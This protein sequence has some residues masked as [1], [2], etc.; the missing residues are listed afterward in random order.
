MS[1][2]FF[3]TLS[4]KVEPFVPRDTGKVAMYTCGPTVYARAHIGNFRTFLVSDLLHR[5][6]KYLGY[7]VTWVMNLT[8]IDDKTIKGANA[9][10][11]SLR[12]Y[13]DKYIALFHE[14]R[15]IIGIT[16]ATMYPRATEHIP[17]MVKMVEDLVSAKHA[18]LV[19]GS[20]YFKIDS[21][22]SYGQLARLNM[23]EMR[24]GERVASDEYEKEDVRDF[25]LWKNW[26]EVDGP[27]AWDTSLGKGRPGWHLE[28]SAMSLKYLGKGFDIHL[29]GVDLIFPHHQNEIAQTEGVTHEPL[30]RY[31]V[32]SEHL[33]VDGQKMSKSLG[34]F[35]T[36]TDMLEKGWRPREIRYGLLSGHYRQRTN[37]QAS[38]LDS[39]K[40]ALARF[41]ACAV[42]LEHADGKGG[43]PELR[44]IVARRE[45]EF[46]DAMDDDLNYPEAL[47]AVF[48]FVREANT[49]C[50]EHKIGSEERAL[51]VATMKRFDSVLG[52]LSLDEAVA[53][54]E[55]AE[56]EALIEVR[57]EARKSKNW[58][59]ADRARDELTARGIILEDRAGKTIWRRK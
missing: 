53:D 25:A 38:G 34:N 16:D 30:A 39:I 37:F 50:Q 5:Y 15:K 19:D 11:I 23:E 1:L 22:P 33:L 31:W 8:D 13:T 21:F 7:D 2:R 28:C 51:A 46:R 36:V 10:G 14:D 32:H 42:N 20:A 3:N 27:V 4:R 29:G 12:D 48:N 24:V 9:E 47:A 45:Q 55:A 6:L 44:D 26:E 54:P 49:L 56:I 57:N 58:A 43:L 52:F 41:E 18:Y 35:F 40:Q 17:E 59:E